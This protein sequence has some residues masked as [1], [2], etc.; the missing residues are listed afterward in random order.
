M[1]GPES[2]TTR[3]VSPESNSI[4]ESVVKTITRDYI[5][6][7]LKPDSHT[8]AMNSGLPGGYDNEYPLNSTVGYR[9]LCTGNYRNRKREKTPGYT[10]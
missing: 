6:I 4:A 7:M 3:G 9:Y 5:S 10:G 1:S 2:C 8:T